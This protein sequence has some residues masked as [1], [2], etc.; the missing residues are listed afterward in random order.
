MQRR[1]PEQNEMVRLDSFSLREF[2]HVGSVQYGSLH[3]PRNLWKHIDKTCSAAHVGACLRVYTKPTGRTSMFLGF[4]VGPSWCG[5]TFTSHGPKRLT[6]GFQ[7]LFKLRGDYHPSYPV[8]NQ[9]Y[10]LLSLVEHPSRVVK[11]SQKFH[12]IVFP[13]FRRLPFAAL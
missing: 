2:S 1:I 11:A 7:V 8:Y 9:S 12:H 4:A 6:F 13:R 10:D 5:S 3:F